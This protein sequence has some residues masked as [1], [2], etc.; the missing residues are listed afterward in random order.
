MQ[1]GTSGILA[2]FPAAERKH[3]T[4]AGFQAVARRTVLRRQNSGAQAHPDKKT[5][6]P[7]Q[8]TGFLYYKDPPIAQVNYSMVAAPSI[9]SLILQTGVPSCNLAVSS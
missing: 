6:M 5:G 4:A 9:I 8:V 2:G 3:T 1:R 7:F